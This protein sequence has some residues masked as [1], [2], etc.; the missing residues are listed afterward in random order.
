LKIA[1][2]IFV[3]FFLLVGGS[4]FVEIN[5]VPPNDTRIIL[6]HTNKTYIAPPCFEQAKTTN[7]LGDSNLGR[8]RALNYQAE[9]SCTEKYFEPERKP[10]IEVLAEKIGFKS[11]KWG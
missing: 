10:I 9:S 11:G 1:L 2:V 8:A 5:S 4:F 6:E 7:N 3:A